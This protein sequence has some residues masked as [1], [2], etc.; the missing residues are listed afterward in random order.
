MTRCPRGFN[1]EIALVVFLTF[2]NR[3]A[4]GNFRSGKQIAVARLRN[5]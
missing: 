5:N 1:I 4:S 3:P 2:A